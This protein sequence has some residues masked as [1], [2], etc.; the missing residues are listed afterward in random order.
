MVVLSH[1][2]D[3]VLRSSG[4]LLEASLNLKPIMLFTLYSNLNVSSPCCRVQPRAVALNS[5]A[6][7][8]RGAELRRGAAQGRLPARVRT[9]VRFTLMLRAELMVSY[10]LTT[11]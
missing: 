8:L 3:L 11:G 7:V 2:A 6:W 9:P 5:V 10:V 1:E 4:L